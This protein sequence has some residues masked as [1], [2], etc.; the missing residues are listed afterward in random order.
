APHNLIRAARQIAAGSLLVDRWSKT[1]SHGDPVGHVAT[2]AL[3]GFFLRRWDLETTI[4]FLGASAEAAGADR[5]KIEADIRDT[6]RKLDPGGHVTGGNK[7]A[8]HFS[9]KVIDTLCDW[10][11]L[12]SEVRGTA[13]IGQ[14]LTSAQVIRL[15]DK[16]NGIRF[17]QLYRGR[18][19]YSQARR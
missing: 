8:D 7:L 4:A 19:L 14:E 6:Q 9:K 2:L 17:A 18:V 3:A 15:T 11:E 13:S 10:L 12:S 5:H 16:G 1:S